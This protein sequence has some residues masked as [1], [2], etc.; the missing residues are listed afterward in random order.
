MKNFASRQ[1][2][3]PKRH[4]ILEHPV[5]KINRSRHREADS[6]TESV[7][8]RARAYLPSLPL[9]ERTNRVFFLLSMGTN[10]WSFDTST[11]RK[12]FNKTCR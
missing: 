7:R 3:R 6:I 1:A 10:K 11:P 12:M 4:A 2:V 8:N 5:G 9:Y